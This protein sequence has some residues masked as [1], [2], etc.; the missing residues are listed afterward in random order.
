MTLWPNAVTAYIL[1]QI[2][3]L[4]HRD[5][6]GLAMQANTRTLVNGYA[7]TGL[8]PF[9]PNQFCWLIGAAIA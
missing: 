8:L 5:R 2:R 9:R 4:A 1:Q 3:L 6:H 7:V